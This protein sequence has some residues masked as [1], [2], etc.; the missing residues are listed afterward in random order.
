[1]QAG[2]PGGAPATLAGDDVEA[3]RLRRVRTR[4]DRLQDAARADRVGQLVQAL[5]RERH[6]GLERAGVQQIQ[7]NL[8][9]AGGRGDVRSPGGRDGD[10]AQQGRQSPAERLTGGF[11]GHQEADRS[12]RC[13][14][15]CSRWSNSAAIAM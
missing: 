1:V 10:V 5:L 9:Q 11:R 14:V 6:P 15:A 8:P 7:R 2:E 12:L 13:A 3:F 4:Q